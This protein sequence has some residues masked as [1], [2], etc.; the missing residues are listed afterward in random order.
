[1][2]ESL[3]NLKKKIL[4]NEIMD[5]NFKV[6]CITKVKTKVNVYFYVSFTNQ[7]KLESFRLKIEMKTQLKVQKL[8]NLITI[9]E[10]IKIK[11][12]FYF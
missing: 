8:C 4:E 2:F 5:R 10:T 3:I 1:M 12:N 7:T 6:D 9:C 11:N